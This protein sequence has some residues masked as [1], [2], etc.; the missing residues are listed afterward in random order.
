MIVGIDFGTSTSEIAYVEENGNVVVIPN[1]LGEL[2][3]P[4]VVYYAEDGSVRVGREA[5]EQALLE[6]ENTFLEVKRLFGQA[7]RLNARGRILTPVDVAADIIRYL[8]DCAKE[9]TG[10]EISTAVITVPA[11]FSDTQR[12]EVMAAGQA[13]GLEVERIINEPTAASLDYG[14]RNMQNCEYILVYDLGGGTLDVTVLELFEGVVDVKSSC[15]NNELGGKDFDQAIVEHIVDVIKKK[16]NIDIMDDVRAAIRVKMAAESC[17]IALSEKTEYEIELPFLYTKKDGPAGF[18]ETVTREMFEG[19]ISDMVCSTNKQI[20][21][22]LYDARLEPDEVDLILLVGGSSRIPCVA[23]FLS[24]T[25][26]SIPRIGDNADLAVVRGAAIQAGVLGNVLNEN[27]IALTD[28]CPY[29]LSTDVLVGNSFFGEVICDILIPRNST[30][31]A[32]VSKSYSTSN[33]DQTSV[34]VMAF[35]GESTIPDE[36][37][38]LNSFYLGDIPKGRAGKESINVTFAYDLNGILTISAEV[39]STGKS[40]TITVDT[41]IAGENLDLSLWKQ[42]PNAK[43][44]R[45]LI[46]K[47]ERLL[48]VHGDEARHVEVCLNELKRALVLEWE[49]DVTNTMADRLEDAIEEFE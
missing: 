36:N 48:K 18:K 31:P 34:A 32:E 1:H 39:I 27:A 4:S 16:D 6:P 47:T 40:T 35:Q 42:S 45:K 44:Y 26:G 24:K 37:I 43:K 38:L 14:I 3:T 15:G 21:T 20:E 30:L 22:A 12:K 7:H 23:S 9:H 33:D 17:K 49:A 29:S 2:I 5:K 41:A 25:F 8:K 10:E 11:Y 13:A 19:L 46:T 28:V